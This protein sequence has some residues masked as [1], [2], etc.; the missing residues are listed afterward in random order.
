MMEDTCFALKPHK[1]Y[2]I[3]SHECYALDYPIF[4]HMKSR[5]LCCTIKCPFYKPHRKDIRLDDS[6]RRGY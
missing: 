2:Y 1:Q 6:I 3:A 4:K 5:G